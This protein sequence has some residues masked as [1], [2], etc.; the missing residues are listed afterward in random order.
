[1]LLDDLIGN[2]KTY[3]LKLNQDPLDIQTAEPRK[4]KNLVLK[5]THKQDGKD[6]DMAL[7]T[8]HSYN[9]KKWISEEG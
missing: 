7:L 1:M 4:I 5:T 6:D 3:Q 2:L 8:R 9:Q